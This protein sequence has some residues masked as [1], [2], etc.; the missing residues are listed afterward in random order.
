MGKDC[1]LGRHCKSFLLVPE[2][3]WEVKD[4]PSPPFNGA[5]VPGG[6]NGKD[7][8]DTGLTPGSGR[9]PGGGHGNP[10]QYFCLED[11][12]DRGAW[13]ATAHGVTK[14]W[15]Q[16]FFISWSAWGRKTLWMRK[17]KPS[18][19][20]RLQLWTLWASQVVRMVKKKPTANTGDIRDTNFIPGGR[21]S[22][23]EGHSNPLQY[24]CLENPMDRRARQATVH[25][26]AKSQTWL[27]TSMIIKVWEAQSQLHSFLF[28]DNGF[29]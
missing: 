7:L 26:D 10:L 3:P 11:P 1:S 17:E 24:F 15:T 6:T 27:S 8:R 4:L 28:A 14:S 13:R 19:L 23:G 21:R 5:V 16:V 9:S 29:K 2:G 22:P 25:G 18:S 20:K 12:T